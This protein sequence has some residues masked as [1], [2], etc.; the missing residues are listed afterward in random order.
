MIQSSHF[1]SPATATSP[2]HDTLTNH[3]ATLDST[4]RS[5]DTRPR[6]KLCFSSGNT[7]STATT[8]IINIVII[9]AVVLVIVVVVVVM[10]VVVVVVVLVMVGV[11]LVVVIVVVVVL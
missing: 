4:L 7:R 5:L 9:V 2:Q 6:V 11:V 10:V 1:P 8:I 3:T